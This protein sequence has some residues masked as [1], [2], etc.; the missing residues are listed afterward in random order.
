MK[1]TMKFSWKGLVLAP[2]AV[3]LVYSA[4]FELST[5]GRSPILG[6]LFFFVLGSIVSYAAT[7]CLLLPSLFLVS[8]LT[9]L[10]A[11]LTCLVGTVLGVVVYL[12]VTWQF[13]LASG[14]DSG[15]PQGSFGEYFRRDLSGGV[16]WAFLVAGLVTAVLYWFLVSRPSRKNDQPTA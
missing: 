3:P 13:Y 14:D 2:L 5:P 10:T 7:T 11:R 9:P 15:P 16:V 1:G 4:L 8:R 12:P 6:F